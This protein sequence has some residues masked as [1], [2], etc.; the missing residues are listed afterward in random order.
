MTFSLRHGVALID[1]P[2]LSLFVGLKARHVGGPACRP[3]SNLHTEISRPSLRI[4]TPG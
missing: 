4:I 2:M 1:A 3:N